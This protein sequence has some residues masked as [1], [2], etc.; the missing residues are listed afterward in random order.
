MPLDIKTYL[1]LAAKRNFN[2]YLDYNTGTKLVSALVDY[3]VATPE[4]KLSLCKLILC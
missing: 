2:K 4:L 1:Q 3:E